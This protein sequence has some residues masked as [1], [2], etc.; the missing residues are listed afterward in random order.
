MASY[1]FTTQEKLSLDAAL[2]NATNHKD[3]TS[4]LATLF[5]TRIPPGHKS[6]I[7]MAIDYYYQLP[8]ITQAKLQIV[9]DMANSVVCVYIPSSTYILEPD[10]IETLDE[11]LEINT[12]TTT[13]EL[14]AALKNAPTAPRTRIPP[15]HKICMDLFI[16]YYEENAPDSRSNLIVPASGPS[17]REL[18]EAD[19]TF[20]D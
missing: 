7:A 15:G 5:K 8:S 10:Q 20:V 1:F 19:D 3:L 11:L 13:E 6:C 9:E 16:S 4:T 17:L 2:N 12:I 18:F 14:Y